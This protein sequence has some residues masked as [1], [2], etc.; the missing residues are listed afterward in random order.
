M[1]L[2]VAECGFRSVNKHSCQGSCIEYICILAFEGK[3]MG[4]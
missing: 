4:S 3:R 2:S 1:A